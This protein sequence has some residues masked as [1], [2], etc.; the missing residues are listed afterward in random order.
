MKTKK[1][2]IFN[3]PVAGIILAIV[4]NGLVLTVI[5][6]LNRYSS[7]NSR[8]YI[9]GVLL[10]IGIVLFTNILFLL[11]YVRRKKSFRVVFVLFSLIMTVILSIG[12]FYIYRGNNSID[13]IIN[14]MA[15]ED[16]EYS[17]ITLDESITLNFLDNEG[18]A[19]VKDE[20]SDLETETKDTLSE[21]SKSLEYVEYSSYR[22]LL[23]AA[24]DDEYNLMVVPSDFKKLLDN[25]ADEKIFKNSKVLLTFNTQQEEDVSDVDVLKD[26][27]TILMLG[28]NEGLSD[29]IIVAS[30][31]PITLRATMT[32]LARDSYV[33]IACYSYGSRDKL[34]HSRAH[35]R[36]CI[37]D[38][39][40]DFLDIEIDFYFES[41]FYALVKTVDVVGGL[42]IESPVSFAGTLPLEGDES[43]SETVHVEEGKHLLDGKQAITFARERHNMPNGDFDRQLNQQYVIRELA[44]KIFATRNIDTL[45]DV[46]DVAKDNI[47]MNL[48][49]RSVSSLMGYA[50]DQVNLAPLDGMDAFRIVQTQVAGTTPL[51][52][53]MSV[54]MPYVKDIEESSRL[55][56]ENISVDYKRNEATHFNFSY[57]EPYE[58]DLSD[59]NLAGIED[60]TLGGDNIDT[61]TFFTIPDFGDWSLQEIRDWGNNR[62]INIFVEE[63]AGDNPGTLIVQNPKGGTY[64]EQP[65]EI[66]IKYV[67]KSREPEPEQEVNMKEIVIPDLRTKN[68]SAIQEWHAEASSEHGDVITYHIDYIDNGSGVYGTILSQNEM[69]SVTYQDSIHVIFGVNTY[70]KTE[71]NTPGEELDEDVNDEI[72]SSDSED[73]MENEDENPD[74]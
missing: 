62:G 14:D 35:S 61:N 3:S 42:E 44:S 19:I 54:V 70:V 41:D 45:M 2:S 48:P 7:I 55:I 37:V 21:Y 56:N 57:T 60:D 9:I 15:V 73:T 65:S 29:S 11:G 26:P 1:T 30:F 22:N 8:Y 23:H 49:I 69:G 58:L 13:K 67:T 53:E 33:P 63:V 74:E 40:E 10:M 16:I 27:F 24:E 51:V 6:I 25:P 66:F 71:D 5:V 46:L 31:N 64:A 32:S 47:V 28:N 38:T 68:E 50:L 18:I 39:V 12:T 43:A 59:P 52:G 72:D 34:N 17:L 36:Q 20:Y 4:S